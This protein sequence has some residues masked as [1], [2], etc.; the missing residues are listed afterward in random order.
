MKLF[1]L[2]LFASYAATTALGPATRTSALN[3]RN[4]MPLR[5][6]SIDSDKSQM[7][8]A[9]VMAGMCLYSCLFASGYWMAGVPFAVLDVAYYGPMGIAMPAAAAVGALTF[10]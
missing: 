9:D 6:D 5:W 8:G 1:G 2:C 10:L 7:M 4:M 3:L